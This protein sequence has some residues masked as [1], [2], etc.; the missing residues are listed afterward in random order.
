MRTVL[1]VFSL[2]VFAIDLSLSAF[3]LWRRGV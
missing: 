3:G 1:L 2:I